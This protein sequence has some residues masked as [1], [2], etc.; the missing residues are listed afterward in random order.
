M[1]EK[2]PV[3]EILEYF[4]EKFNKFDEQF[5]ALTASTGR[6]AKKE[7]TFKYAGNRF[8]CEFNEEVTEGLERLQDLVEVGSKKRSTE[9][10]TSLIKKLDKRNKCIKL[11]DRSPAGWE[12]VKEYLSDD[13][14]EDSADDRKMR[15]AEKTALGKMAV[16]KRLRYMP[17]QSSSSSITTPT[18][19]S[20]VSIPSKEPPPPPR[21]Y[22]QRGGNSSGTTTNSQRY[23][24]A[25]RSRK[26]CFGC[27]AYG[28]FRKD[29]RNQQT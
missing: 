15:R 9:L 21:H 3:E 2:G 19:A 26:Q 20:V 12:T 11:A 5:T 27:G 24:P 13:L 29:C 7:T 14:A 25:E 4:E 16:N 28:H 17:Y 1:S 18:V 10:I 23:Q 6:K 8:Q 22:S